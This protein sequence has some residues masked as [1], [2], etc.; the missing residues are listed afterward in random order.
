[1]NHCGAAGLTPGTLLA[2][3]GQKVNASAQEKARQSGRGSL[4]PGKAL[5]NLIQPAPF[6][7]ASGADE[8][9]GCES[10]APPP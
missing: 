5:S 2:K 9:V 1:M 10:T 8:E 3:R 6:G 7:E 4:Q